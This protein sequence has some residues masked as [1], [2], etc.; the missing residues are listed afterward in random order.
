LN[1]IGNLS[2]LKENFYHKAARKSY[3]SEIKLT[4]SFVRIAKRD[5]FKI[6]GGSRV[7]K[8]RI[9]DN[10]SDI[11]GNATSV[12]GTYGQEYS[13]KTTIEGKTI[14]SGVAS[15]EPSIGNDENP[16]REP[17]LYTQAM[18]SPLASL[19]FLPRL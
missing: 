1:A 8:I 11:S 7:K 19:C 5:G 13:Y 16:M 6:G 17:I 14:S 3:A 4:R 12:S 9:N 15:Y 2:E 18:K 10:W